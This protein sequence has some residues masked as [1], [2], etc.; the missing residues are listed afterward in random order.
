MQIIKRVSIRE[1]KGVR[2]CFTSSQYCKDKNNKHYIG[3]PV[4]G[5]VCST[6]NL[7]KCASYMIKSGGDESK[8]AK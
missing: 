7:L 4:R 1:E 6:Y 5:S 8:R 3:Y 2:E